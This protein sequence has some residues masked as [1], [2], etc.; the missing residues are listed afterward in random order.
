MVE[1]TKLFSVYFKI[2]NL[3]AM[4]PAK[5]IRSFISVMK[6]STVRVVFKILNI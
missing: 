6:R 3:R 1:A 5:T 2:S 4:H